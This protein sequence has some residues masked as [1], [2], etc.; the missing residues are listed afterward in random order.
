[1]SGWLDDLFEWFGGHEKLVGF[2]I[3]LSVLTFF[4]S[5]AIVS[6]LIV[7]MPADYFDHRKP[8]PDSWR[9]RH[10]AIRVLGIILKNLVGVVVV[11]V[12]IVLILPGVPGQG[13]LTILIGLTLL[14]FPGKRTLEVRF[15]RLRPVL[16]AINWIRAKNH[17]PPLD[18]PPD[19]P[20]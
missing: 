16:T 11:A 14:N 2:G 4:G 17:R 8:P 6:A 7:R 20:D 13:V 12:G 19:C 18:L 9:G 3:A 15:V 10:P 1:M 5:I